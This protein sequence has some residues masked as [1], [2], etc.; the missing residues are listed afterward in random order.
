MRRGRM[1]PR[2]GGTNVRPSHRK[3]FLEHAILRLFRLRSY[4]SEDCGH[5]FLLRINAH[6]YDLM[7][8]KRVP[9][10]MLSPR[11]P[12]PPSG[13]SYK[14]RVR[15]DVTPAAPYCRPAVK[16]FSYLESYAVKRIQRDSTYPNQF[17]SRSRTR[18]YISGNI[19]SASPMVCRTRRK[20][21][22]PYQS[23]T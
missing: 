6:T 15:K 21:R 3:N 14:A 19:G 7:I 23:R 12:L 2:C 10:P 13:D 16:C 11:P 20:F 5:D 22:F 4:R 17:R 8:P 18:L 1:C 9:D